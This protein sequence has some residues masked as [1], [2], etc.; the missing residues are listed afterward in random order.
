[1]NG[2]NGGGRW[3]TVA[4]LT[5]YQLYRVCGSSQNFLLIQTALK[6]SFWTGGHGLCQ[7]ISRSASIHIASQVTACEV[8]FYQKITNYNNTLSTKML[9]I[10]IGSEH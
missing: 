3:R 4:R 10:L 8:S 5:E 2:T 7:F 9:V 6:K 1:M